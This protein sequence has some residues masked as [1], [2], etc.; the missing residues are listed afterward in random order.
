MEYETARCA[1]AG[2]GCQRPPPL[3][4]PSRYRCRCLFLAVLGMLVG[5]LDACGRSSVP[6]RV[7]LP[8]RW[9][10]KHLVPLARATI[11]GWHEG[12]AVQILDPLSPPVGMPQDVGEV[13]L[14]LAAAATP[15]VAVAV[16][17]QS[18][19]AT[20][21]VGP[22]YAERRIPLIAPTATS[23]RLRLLA[24][25]VFPLA[26]N[27][28][29]EGDFLTSFA[30]DHLAARDVTIFYLM[31]DEYGLDLR[32]ALVRALDRHGITAV[33]QVG[34]TTRSNFPRQVA[35]SLD[36]AVPQVVV[37]AARG[38][39]AAPITRAIHDRLP[40]VPV[41]VG[42]GVPLDS[43]FLKATGPAVA[44]IYAA[45]WWHP[46]LPDTLSRTFAA[47][48]RAVT[49]QFPSAADAMYYDALLLAA[50]AVREA[51]G[52]PGAVRRYLSELG[53][54]RPPYHGVTGNISFTPERKINLL[55]TRVI[56]GAVVI[57]DAPGPER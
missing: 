33:D 39:Q 54:E 46:A 25:W 8:G 9:V 49:G 44:S 2:S 52:S 10:E 55:M 11:G 56:D 22:V 16:G 21:L 18:S 23:D 7:V 20:L 57:V 34:I 14:A 26:P 13:D 37:V 27:D 43:T 32:D 40:E 45:A 38:P 17:P 29:A 28:Q 4:F 15:G 5:S 3:A 6:A 42:D 12:S 36:R 24:T 35:A 19:R 48:F 31:N 30:L 1:P 53:R 41:L 50:R 47:R 51:G